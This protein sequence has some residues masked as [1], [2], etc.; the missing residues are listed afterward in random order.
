LVLVV[1]DDPLYE[2]FDAQVF[3]DPYLTLLLMV[4]EHTTEAFLATNTLAPWRQTIANRLIIVLDSR[5]MGVLRDITVH[6][7][8]VRVPI[9]LAIGVGHDGRVDLELARQSFARVIAPLLLELVGLRRDGPVPSASPQV[10]EPT[11]RSEAFW[12]GFEMALESIYGEQHRELLEELRAREP[13]D[14]EA[15]D[16]L[17]RYELGPRNRLRFSFEGNAPATKTRSPEEAARTPGVVATFV[18]R[19]LN[20]AG[21]FYPQRYMLWFVSYEPEEIPYG[22]F[23]LAVSRMPRHGEVSIQA[24]IESYAETFPAERDSVVALAEEVLGA[25]E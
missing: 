1:D 25:Y 8:D 24:F 5:D 17:H 15:L 9:E 19:L 6:H 18:C 10:H 22:K 12:V 7:N 11:T 4:F 21:S 16:R 3:R 2:Q 23:L 13:G 20:E 14:P